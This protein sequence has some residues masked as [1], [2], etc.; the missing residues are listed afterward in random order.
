MLIAAIDV[1]GGDYII[2]DIF[3]FSNTEPF[4]NHFKE[5]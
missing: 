2:E 4:N 3:Q 5:F 1:Y